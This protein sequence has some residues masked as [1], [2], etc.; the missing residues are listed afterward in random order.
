MKKI[1]I[2][3]IL[4][5]FIF[6]QD[7]SLVDSSLNIIDTSTNYKNFNI[8][9]S[10]NNFEWGYNKELF[11]IDSTLK[12]FLSD[13]NFISYDDYLGKDS[14]RFNYSFSNKKFWK[15][16]IYYLSTLKLNN[17]DSLSN[18]FYQIE[19]I[20]FQKYGPPLRTSQNEIGSNREYNFSNFPKINRIYYR[21]SW[22][23]EN[24]NIELVLDNITETSRTSKIFN[25]FRRPIVLYY[26]NLDYYENNSVP[27]DS[28]EFLEQ[29]L[30]DNY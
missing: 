20:L 22:S 19:K 21:S 29:N 8:K 18:K 4:C 13:S 27:S 7:S 5:S 2:I 23:I 9:K 3:L 12:N 26:Y 6:S 14:V 25:N 30:L 17:I 16:D 28:T 1:P 24:I 10:Y 11:N 15:V